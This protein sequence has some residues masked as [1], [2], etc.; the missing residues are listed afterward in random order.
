[1][2]K[3]NAGGQNAA[4]VSGF[5]VIA[6]RLLQIKSAALLPRMP[7]ETDEEEEDPGETLARQ[8]I[9]YKRFKELSGVLA[10]REEAGLRTYL[11]V[12]PPAVKIDAKLDMTGV[13]LTDL[14]Q[15]ALDI[16]ASKPDLPALSRVVAMPRVTIRE[17]IRII[18][19]ELR[20]L[21]SSTFQKFLRHDHDRLEV[22]VT[23]LAMLELIKRHV[24]EASQSDLFSDIEVKPTGDWNEEEDSQL[25]F[26]E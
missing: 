3:E 9:A 19:D 14:T 5:L 2:Q 10:Q 6:A 20:N 13:T 12:A 4:E 11:R 26:I 1:M 23:F 22:V 21:G 8:L 17:K 7:V 15:A 25:E 18:V 16:F 24:V